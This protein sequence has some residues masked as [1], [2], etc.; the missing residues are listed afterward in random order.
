ME[1]CRR[2]V[3][4]A[5]AVMALGGC[6]GDDSSSPGDSTLQCQDLSDLI[7]KGEDVGSFSPDRLMAEDV[8]FDFRTFFATDAQVLSAGIGLDPTLFDEDGV[9]N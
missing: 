3:V 5:G 1:R 7:A 9:P 4:L 8:P 6:G 2:L